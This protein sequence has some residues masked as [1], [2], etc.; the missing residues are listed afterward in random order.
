MAFFSARAFASLGERYLLFVDAKGI[1]MGTGM[2]AV[3]GRPI[4]NMEEIVEETR[5]RCEWT[6]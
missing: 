6:E 3:Y 1:S 4:G 2:M 5:C